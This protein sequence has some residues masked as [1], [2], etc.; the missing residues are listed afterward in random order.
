MDSLTEMPAQ[1]RLILSETDIAAEGPPVAVLTPMPPEARLT[2]PAQSLF[3]F[4]PKKDR[5]RPSPRS[6][7]ATF[8]ARMLVFGG[9]FGL[10]AYGAD[11]MY[12]VVAVGGVTFLKW[13][14]VCLFVA[15]FS[16]IALAFTSAC[17]GFIWLLFARPKPPKIPSLL[18][19]RTAIVMPI[20]NEAPARV[21]GTLQAI[22]EDVEATGHGAAFDWF[23]LSDTTSPEI[24]VAE[25]RAFIAMRQ[26]LG[27][28]ARV[29]YRHRPK[30]LA[31]K[32][33][34]IT[35][36]VT[37]WGGHYDHMLVLD[38]DSM[39][40]GEAIVGLAA[41]MEADPGA[42]II[43]TLPLIINRNTLFARVQQFSARIY[44]PVIA[45]GL[46]A[47][48]GR[49]GNYWGH[50]AIIRT[51][52]FAAHCGL[53]T[54]KGR[55][56]FGGHVL[57]HDFVEAA[58]IL[59]AGYSVYMLP[60]ISGSYEE[61]PPSLI[62]MSERDRRW[63]QGNLQHSRIL[64]AKGLHWAS[65]QHLAAGIMGYVASPLWMLQL[66]VGIVIVFQA[67]YIRPEYFTSEFTLFPTWPRFDA[68]KSL[69]LFAL[70][71]AILLTPKLFGLV[72][73]LVRGPVRRGCGGA[74]RLVVSTVFETIMSALLA[75]IMMLIQSG[76]VL[77]F[78]FGFDTGWNPQRRDDGSIPFM[79]IVRRHR[80]HVAMGVLSL[81]A[82]L[83]ISPSLVAWMSPTILGLVLAIFIS[84]A[85]A[86]LSFGIIL[87][88]AGFLLTP[89]EKSKP[90][91]VRRAN[92]LA[93][94]FAHLDETADGLKSIYAEPEFRTIHEAFLPLEPQRRRGEISVE[95]ALADAKLNEAQSIDEAIDWLR[96]NERMVVL[97]D[98][99]LLARLV[100]L[101]K[102]ASPAV[103]EPAV[104][105]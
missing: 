66:L 7:F 102:C 21:F 85:T 88:R 60:G 9:G 28:S 64:P 61:S 72:L 71:M 105:A 50:N 56:P 100:A 18:K 23:F 15:N 99:D 8:V 81:I 73:A 6:G 95:R 54:L 104:Q 58:L 13:A 11:Q 35:D 68:E 44:G 26:R 14:L 65:R 24:F 51:R 33:G 89:E 67:S 62:D 36:F 39:M 40:T 19:A 84:W 92:K 69:A 90:P 45:A 98:P 103:S 2:M 46:A 22:F 10:S 29:F 86:Q 93:R 91:V 78:L 83:L 3:Q 47:W 80:S 63:C 37:R 52:A 31:R 82:G 42:G 41:A 48:M 57:S 1:A 59:R 70:T 4:D 34:N 97:L 17:V 27:P 53:P 38:A 25:E 55:P 79:G 12:E 101:P 43:Q 76:H 32:A 30:N 87:R 77:H 5:V 96:P 74:L 94:Q 75:P 49:D 20:Y 16:W